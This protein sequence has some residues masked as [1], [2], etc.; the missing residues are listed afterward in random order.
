[1]PNVPN[2]PNDPTND[3][4]GLKY[5]DPAAIKN[6]ITMGQYL[7]KRATEPFA[8]HW[9]GVLAA[10]ITG[11][12]GGLERAGAESAL[13]NNQTLMSDVLK[14]AGSAKD[15]A[16]A[17]S[18]LTGSGIPGMGEKGLDLVT[19]E[20]RAAA[21]RAASFANQQKMFQMQ[22]NF[23]LEMLPRRQ[24][25]ELDQAQKLAEMRARLEREGKDA[26]IKRTIQALGLDAAPSAGDG[27][28]VPAQPVPQ[29]TPA[30][31]DPHLDILSGSKTREQEIA[32]RKKRA[33]Q[34][35]L[36]GDVKGASKILNKEE[37]LKEH[38]SKD[39]LYSERMIRTELDLRRIQNLDE[40]GNAQGYDPTPSWKRAAPDWNI[41][42][43]GKGQEYQRASREWI[44][45]L[46]RKDTGAAVTQTEWDL[47]FPTYFPQPG[48]T[49]Q[50]VLDK[51]R[52]RIALAKGLRNSSGPA[53]NQMFPDFDA[54]MKQHLAVIDPEKYGQ[55]TPQGTDAPTQPPK[56]N[57]TSLPPER[58]KA[59]A[60]RLKSALSG[61]N[62]EVE[63]QQF[64]EAFGDEALASIL[65][66]IGAANFQP[67]GGG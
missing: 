31:V 7:T 47:Y 48:D 57:F 45:G 20:R 51:Q 37:D 26:D 30:Q 3:P 61:P 15:N 24:A 65:Q 60:L 33:A 11:A 12:H 6:R 23:E 63:K 28:A 25:L 21:D 13:S 56:A 43:S 66:I 54:R 19:G 5:M 40:K 8:P 39:A 64:R 32:E 49:A 41:A 34:A 62:A 59:A 16:T 2:D 50:V 36:M 52:A 44:A 38:Q 55:K 53:F 18:I 42:T 4:N 9:T 10:G 67:Q 1:M 27:A 29:A 46:L 35:V 17:A 58:Q 22:K 14:R